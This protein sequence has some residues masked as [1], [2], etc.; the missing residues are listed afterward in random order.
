[1][2]PAS[3]SLFALAA[4]ALHA[5]LIA[6]AI[7]GLR[8]GQHNV[9]P[10]RPAQVQVQLLR[11][12]P[13]AAEKSPATPVQPEPLPQKPVREHKPRASSKPTPHPREQPAA[14]AKAPEAPAPAAQPSPDAAPA[15]ARSNNTAAPA[16][17]ATAP[18]AP[19]KRGVFVDPTY[20]AT[21]TEKW[22]P[23]QAKRYGDQGTVL[24][25]VTVSPAG[26]AEKVELKKGSGYPLLDTA[27]IDLAKSITYRPATLDGKPVSDSFNL[28]VTFQLHD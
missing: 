4:A 6:L 17:A 7:N 27:A 21:E 26:R 14:P 20:L 3:S 5:A 11:E 19:V 25:H 2:K 12:Q 18:A 13:K 9:P 24:L 8:A 23:R 22:Y 15:P 1:M 16:A 10:P 28:P